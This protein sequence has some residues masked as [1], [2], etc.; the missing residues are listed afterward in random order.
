MGYSGRK[1]VNSY[2]NRLPPNFSFP[3]SLISLL[4][5]QIVYYTR[6]KRHPPLDSLIQSHS[7]SFMNPVFRRKFFI[8]GAINKVSWYL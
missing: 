7:V 3:V 2:H 1:I 8:P 4:F 6:T 5:A